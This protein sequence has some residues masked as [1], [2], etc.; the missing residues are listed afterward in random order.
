VQF[1]QKFELQKET[2]LA[3]R[4]LFIF[5]QFVHGRHAGCRASSQFLDLSLMCS[6]LQLGLANWISERQN[7]EWTTCDDG[8]SQTK[9]YLFFYK[10]NILNFITYVFKEMGVTYTC[11]LRLNYGDVSYSVRNFKTLVSTLR[12]F[13]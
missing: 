3:W 5:S 12:E 1:N 6:S 11:N 7:N 8:S 4:V 2:S 9:Y 13:F 10:N